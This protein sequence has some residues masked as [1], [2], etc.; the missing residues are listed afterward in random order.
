MPALA[1]EAPGGGGVVGLGLYLG[2]ST[3][4]LGRSAIEPGGLSKIWFVALPSPDGLVKTL[5]IVASTGR[6]VEWAGSSGRAVVRRSSGGDSAGRVHR[7]QP[8]ARWARSD[9]F[10]RGPVSDTHFPWPSAR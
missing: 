9:Q 3:T 7:R 6:L 2:P 8:W 1:E 4:D 5:S 10:K